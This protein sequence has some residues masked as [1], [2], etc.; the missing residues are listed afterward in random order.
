[1]R[2]LIAV[3]RLREFGRFGREFAVAVNELPAL[4]ARRDMRPGVR[5]ALVETVGGV[6]TDASS[7]VPRAA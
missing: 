4:P 1:M 2:K 3:D 6:V 7:A 5:L